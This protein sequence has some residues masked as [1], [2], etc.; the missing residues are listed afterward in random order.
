MVPEHVTF[1]GYEVPDVRLALDTYP[2]NK[3][4]FWPLDWT[5]V[6]EERAESMGEIHMVKW[7]RENCC[8]RWDMTHDG[9]GQ[10]IFAF[11]SEEE[12]VLFRLSF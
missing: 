11:E 5:L 2:S 8:H 7:M 10:R 12:A 1:T 9:L 3:P 6:I 4:A